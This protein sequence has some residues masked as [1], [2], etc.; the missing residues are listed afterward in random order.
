MAAI[1]VVSI[2]LFETLVD[3]SI[4]RHAVWPTFLGEE[5]SP[6]RVEH[7]W[8]VITEAL[9]TALDQLNASAQ[10]QSLDAVFQACFTDVFARLRIA[11]D[12]AEAARVLARHHAD[13]PWFP[14]AVPS[15]DDIRGRYRLCLASDADDGM[16]G[17]HVRQ[18]PFDMCFT[19]E[20]L[21]VY[22]GDAQNRFFRALVG[23]YAIAPQHVLHVGDSPQE[24]VA[25]QRMGLETCWVNRN[26]RRWPHGGAPAYEVTSLEDLVTLLGTLT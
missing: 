24:I 7:D 22:K 19:S 17:P 16:L 21:R 3:V 26:G 11:F 14:D 6:A 1:R 13:S 15:L 5:S 25:A 4:G 10:Y 9:F 8:T 20:R 2:D 12:P 23:H 18:Y